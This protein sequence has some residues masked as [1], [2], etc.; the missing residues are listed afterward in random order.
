MGD[1]KSLLAAC[2][3]ST[4]RSDSSWLASGEVEVAATSVSASEATPR[5]WRAGISPRGKLPAGEREGQEAKR[6]EIDN[7]I[8]D[9]SVGSL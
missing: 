8:Q 9:L 7:L 6:Q 2:G 1:I 5:T 3:L 4:L